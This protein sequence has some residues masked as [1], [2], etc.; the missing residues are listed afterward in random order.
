[1]LSH[2]IPLLAVAGAFAQPPV[3]V[4]D[5][6]VPVAPPLTDFYLISRPRPPQPPPAA[7]EGVDD[8]SL[9]SPRLLSV[10]TSEAADGRNAWNILKGNY[11]ART[12]G[13]AAAY[14]ERLCKRSGWA[15]SEIVDM[16]CEERQTGIMGYKWEC[17]VYTQCSAPNRTQGMR[18]SHNS[19]TWES[20][21][22]LVDR[23]TR[24]YD[25]VC[26]RE[27]YSGVRITDESCTNQ[28]TITGGRRWE[29]DF[30]LNCTG[31]RP[32]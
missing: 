13:A 30:Y 6:A 26:K 16:A 21:R 5:R 14:H 9:K 28:E 23:V 27:G 22:E 17:D 11:Q 18:V 20:K 29:C 15:Q 3:P 32:R 7:Q 25:R 10:W 31:V 4:I 2:L 8:A 1:M 24:K 19:D 12:R